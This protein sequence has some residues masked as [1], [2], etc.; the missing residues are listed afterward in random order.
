MKRYNVS[1]GYSLWIAFGITVLSILSLASVASALSYS[2]E[3][4]WQYHKDITISNDGGSALNDYQVLVNLTSDN[5]PQKAS[6]SGDDI[7]FVD[8]GNNELNYWIESWDHDSHTA[9]IWVN[10]TNIPA[11]GSTVIRMYYGNPN[12][13]SASNGTKTFEFFDDFED[14][15]IGETPAG[16]V[17][18]SGDGK[19]RYTATADYRYD[20]AKSLKVVSS[21]WGDTSLNHK[22]SK[23]VSNSVFQLK[24]YPISSTYGNHGFYISNYPHRIEYTL[25]SSNSMSTRYFS[26]NYPDAYHSTTGTFRTNEWNTLEIRSLNGGFELYSNGNKVHEVQD[27]GVYNFTDIFIEV[28]NADSRTSYWDQVIIRKYTSPEPSVNVGAE[29]SNVAENFTFAHITDVHIGYYPGKRYCIDSPLNTIECTSNNMGMSVQ[30]FIDIL[31][32]VEG[33]KPRFILITGDLVQYDNRNFFMAFRNLIK[34]TDIPVNITP[35][36]HDRRNV[37]TRD[38]L[39]NYNNILNPINNPKNPGD[40]NYSFDYMGYR[41]IS[42]DSGADDDSHVDFTPESGGLS[43]DQMM[44]LRTEFNSNAPKIIFMHHPAIGN[45]TKYSGSDD[46]PGGN[47]GT[48]SLNRWNFINYTRDRNVQ[49][50]L[51]GHSHENAIF[52][53]SGDTA[54][55][56]SL[57]R[58]L[59]IQTQNRGYRI[60]EVKDGKVNPYNSERTPRFIRNSAAFEPNTTDAASRL[61]LHAFDS[62]G[63]HTGMIAGCDDFELGIPDS[64]YTGDYG[65]SSTPQVIVDYSP[66]KEFK[67]Y[68]CQRINTLNSMMNTR[69]LSNSQNIQALENVPFNLTIEKQRETF[70]TGVYFY[71]T[72]I[73]ES[74]IATVNVIESINGYKMDI[75]LDGDGTIDRLIYPDSIDTTLVKPQNNIDVIAYNGAGTINLASDRGHFIK[76]SSFNPSSITV[77]PAYEFPYGLFAFNITGLRTGEAVDIVITLQQNIPPDTLYWKYGSTSDDMTPHWYPIMPGSNDGDNVITLQLRDGGI[78]DDDLTANGIIVDAGGPGI[79]LIGNVTGGGWILTASN[80]KA[81]FGFVA[82]YENAVAPGGNLKYDDNAAG[83]KINGNVT[84]LSV[85]RTTGTSTF[86]GTARVNGVEGYAYIVTVTDKG[87]PGDN[88]TFAIRIPSISYKAG[89]ALMGGNIQV[90]K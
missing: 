34:G 78:G 84:T 32:A 75:D 42:L 53:I 17:F 15:L 62:S 19:G 82:H 28:D 20:G 36:N 79:P 21:N 11:A 68:S 64:Y 38:D 16:W 1:R 7:I 23:H 31:H 12:A 18:W 14:D 8:A 37:I 40:N 57:N 69:S 43:D 35:G 54:T 65:G 4:S 3:G 90:H 25:F 66:V 33:E 89:G 9:K 72:I 86:G 46:A 59:F 73:V 49:L 80:K 58:P 55:N 6:I 48:I 87:E 26:P 76:A 41:F 83:L 81:N 67:I 70:T 56:N 39:S 50:V 22:L 85:D 27:F 60:I 29:I 47:D 10:V 2:G 45:R 5:F 71:N 44:R 61:G 24:A 77:K 63:G 51:T 88:D 52:D 30:N 74:S 13:I